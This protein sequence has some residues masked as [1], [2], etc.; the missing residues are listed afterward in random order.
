MAW[1]RTSTRE[2]RCNRGSGRSSPRAKCRACESVSRAGYRSLQL[3]R[4]P[5][6]RPFSADIDVHVGGA[7]VTTRIDAESPDK[8]RVLELDDLHRQTYHTAVPRGEFSIPVGVDR[9]VRRVAVVVLAVAPRA[10]DP[11]IAV[12]RPEPGVH[13]D[14]DVGDSVGAVPPGDLRDHQLELV[15]QFRIHRCVARPHTPLI[16]I[17][18]IR[19]L[20]MRGDL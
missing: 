3:S 15:Q 12:Q 7:G 6:P 17:Q 4:S 5:P 10:P 14:L 13:I 2:S 16:V 8:I 19:D 18:E 9:D 1:A 11:P 20:E